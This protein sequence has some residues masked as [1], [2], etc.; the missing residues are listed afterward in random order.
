MRWVVI[1]DLQVPDHDQKAVDSVCEWISRSGFDGMLIVGDE[2]DSPEPSRWNRGYAGEY[3]GTLQK[4][5]DKTHDVLA[6][7]RD[8]LATQAPI[9]LMR[10]NHGDRIQTYV[11]RY[12]PA[13]SSLKAL[14][15]QQLLGFDELNVTYHRTPFEFAP[16]WLL[17]HGDEGSLIGTAGG[18]AMGL[19]KKWGKSVIC[20][21]THKAGMQHQHLSVNGKITRH[22]WGVEVGH[23]MDMRK[24]NYLKA[25][26]ANWQ[27]AVGVITVDGSDVIPTLVPLYK[28]K[29]K[30]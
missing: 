11:H 24:A 18:T 8:A 10:S 30:F 26:S 2:S 4:N 16:G 1:S 25:G 7:F 9:H 15:Y 14:E 27:Q 3:A 12:A 22:L 19:A 20:G 5:L 13:L 17:A 21:H 29:V 23:L 6:Q 28:S